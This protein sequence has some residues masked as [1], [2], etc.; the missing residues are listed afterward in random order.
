M[1]GLSSPNMIFLRVT[2]KL[3]PPIPLR[4]T[5]HLIESIAG[6]PD[7]MSFQKATVIF[8]IVLCP[9]MDGYLKYT[10]LTSLTGTVTKW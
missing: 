9:H 4:E 8:L 6:V 5:S 2:T 1:S 7:F 3:L 10:A